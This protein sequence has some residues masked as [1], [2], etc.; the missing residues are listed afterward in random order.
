MP[1]IHRYSLSLSLHRLLHPSFRTSPVGRR[2]SF[3]FVWVAGHHAPPLSRAFAAYTRLHKCY[4][5][6]T[7]VCP[8]DCARASQPN[9]D[10][11]ACACSCL[12]EAAALCLVLSLRASTETPHGHHGCVGSAQCCCRLLHSRSSVLAPLSPSLRPLARVD[13][14]LVAVPL[15]PRAALCSVSVSALCRRV[16]LAVV[17][18]ASVSVCVSLSPRLAS[19]SCSVVGASLTRSL[20]LCPAQSRGDTTADSAQR[21]AQRTAWRTHRW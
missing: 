7:P 4:S 21:H 10:G 6:S 3:S 13:S 2:V 20:L 15:F 5:S 18:V 11:R 14:P 19:S 17:S 12:C 9:C 16:A 1:P 8:V